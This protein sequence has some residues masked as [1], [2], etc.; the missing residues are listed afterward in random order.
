M[1]RKKINLPCADC[2]INTADINNGQWEYYMVTGETWQA[3]GPP[4]ATLNKYTTE[5]DLFGLVPAP[6]APYFL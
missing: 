6:P 5:V 2:G 1:T 4:P 3:A